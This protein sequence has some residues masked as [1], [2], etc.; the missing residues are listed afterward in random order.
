M[1]YEYTEPQKIF[2]ENG[3]V[4]CAG[5]AKK[6]CFIYNNEQ[7]RQAKHIKESVSYFLSTGEVSLFI[8]MENSGLDFYIKI[9]LANLKNGNVISD[10]AYK[11][12]LLGKTELL[13]N[14]ENGQIVFSD[15]R[16]EFAIVKV[17]NERTIKCNFFD[18]G[19][20]ADLSFE[21]NID[22]KSG[23]ILEQVAPFERDR[24][25]FYYKRFMPVFSATGS[26]K[27]G[28]SE[29]NLKPENSSVYIDSTSYSKPRLHSYQRLSADYMRGDNRFSLCLASR[30]GD[31]R[32]GSENSFFL[33]GEM[34]KLYKIEVK[35]ND[36]RIDR[37][38]YFKGGIE[39]VDI[40]FK[41]NKINDKAMVTQMGNTSVTFGV[42][43]GKLKR[44]DYDAP[45]VLDNIPAHMVFSEF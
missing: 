41:P 16:I 8:G 43:F 7:S 29:Y 30:I 4:M 9:A 2:E 24:K 34:N 23:D 21:F 36:G 18:F 33:N 22:S 44:Y 39:A 35:N 32:N 12:Q 11:K 28:K 13:E 42:L 26:I 19:D 1:Q 25:Y 5:W 27:V 38:W 10:Y 37:P 3:E 15:K 45:L 20:K 17:K 14:K 31:N 6:P 40:T